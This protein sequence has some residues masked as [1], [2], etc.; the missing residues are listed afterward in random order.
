MRS[1]VRSIGIAGGLLVLA[2]VQNA[3]ALITETVEFTTSFPFAVGSATV[4][5]GSYTI[6]PDEDDPRILMLTGAHASVLFETAD[7]QARE[8]PSKTE[9]VFQRYGD[10]Y[11]LKDI[12]MEGEYVGAESKASEAE[13]HMKKHE[14]NGEERVAARKMANAS[15]GH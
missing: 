2:G 15:N 5:A 13:R 7:T 1:F 3:D 12:W 4:P 14:S 11:V 9:V 10:E 8:R 6:R